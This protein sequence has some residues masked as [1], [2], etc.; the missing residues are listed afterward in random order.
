LIHLVRDH[1][2]LEA[3][4]AD[5]A[6]WLASTAPTKEAMASLLESWSTRFKLIRIG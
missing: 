6:E 3:A 1:R 5:A 4:R 2:L